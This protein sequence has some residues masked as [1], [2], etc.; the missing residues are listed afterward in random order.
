MNK[1][2]AGWKVETVLCY[3]FLSAVFLEHHRV[4]AT[5][6]WAV[7]LFR[8]KFQ[9][10]CRYLKVQVYRCTCISQLNRYIYVHVF[11]YDN[12]KWKEFLS[13]VSRWLRSFLNYS[14]LYTLNWFGNGNRNGKPN[15]NLRNIKFF[16]TKEE[17]HQPT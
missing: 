7:V 8:Q 14:I 2:N 10:Q 11:G 15:K 16:F 3:S 9:F 17:Q 12:K 4:P 5:V 13:I 1:N 6:H